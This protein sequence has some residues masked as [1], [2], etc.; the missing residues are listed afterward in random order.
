M[1]ATLINPGSP[2]ELLQVDVL[3]GLVRPKSNYR[4]AKSHGDGACTRPPECNSQSSGDRLWCASRMALTLGHMGL[5]PYMA[6]DLDE[7]DRKQNATEINKATT[8]QSQIRVRVIMNRVI[9]E[10]FQ[11]AA[12]SPLSK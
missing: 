5:E 6:N 7:S 4:V 1:K 9:V 2:R 10:A 8:V 11:A 12:I 3:L